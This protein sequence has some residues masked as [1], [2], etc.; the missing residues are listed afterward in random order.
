[1]AYMYYHDSRSKWKNIE[2]V[3]TNR[4]L[5]CNDFSIKQILHETKLAAGS[6]MRENIVK[7]VFFYLHISLKYPYTDW[8]NI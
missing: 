7:K 4:S 8:Y 5:R 6:V 2:S 3:E 1:M